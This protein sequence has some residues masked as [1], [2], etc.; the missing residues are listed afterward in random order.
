MTDNTK[1][2]NTV[3]SFENLDLGE[4]FVCDVETGICGPAEEIEETKQNKQKVK[5]QQHANNDLV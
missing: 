4:G 3:T 5:E 2:E 1:E